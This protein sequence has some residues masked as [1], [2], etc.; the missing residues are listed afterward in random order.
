MYNYST[1]V[2]VCVQIAAPT[3]IRKEPFDSLPL[4]PLGG[5]YCWRVGQVHPNV[6]GF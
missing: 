6:V 2:H 1:W 3:L 5:H 4:A